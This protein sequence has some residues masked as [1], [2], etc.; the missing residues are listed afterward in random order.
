MRCAKVE[1]V[2]HEQQ[3]AFLR[4]AE[5][6]T[7]YGSHESKAGLSYLFV[8]RAAVCCRSAGSTDAQHIN[9][10]KMTGWIIV[11]PYRCRTG[12]HPI[13]AK[14]LSWC[15]GCRPPLPCTLTVS[16]L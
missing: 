5:C 7:V 9:I 11:S 14:R 3:R 12:Y 4:T 8:Y 10:S 15:C 16:G 6:G 1:E 2:L 13:A